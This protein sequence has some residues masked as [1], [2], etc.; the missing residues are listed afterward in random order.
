[1]GYLEKMNDAIQYVEE[2]LTGDIDYDIISKIA[3][4]EKSSFQRMFLVMTD[5]TISEYIRKR[6]LQCAIM[7]LVETTDQVITIAMKYG[8]DSAAS[9][10][11][12]IRSFTN[13]TPSEIRK[14]KTQVHFPRIQF[15][16]VMKEGKMSMNDKTIVRIEEHYGEKVIRFDVDCMEPETEA[17]KLMSEWCRENVTDRVGRR[18]LGLAPKGHHPDGKEHENAEEHVSHPYS[19]MMVLLGE[20]G[21]QDT[22]CGKKVEDAP[23]GLFLVNEVLLNQYDEY[24]NLDMA[25]SMMKASEAFMEF[26]KNMKG[27]DFDYEQGI[28]YEEHI[29]SERWFQEGGFPDGFRMWVPIK[30]IQ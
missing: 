14:R 28:F 16:M 23:N 7:D 9:F 20:E 10:T 13:Q 3:C 11:R 4:L 21:Q 5:M 15:E 1:M 24:G 18:Y 17:W 22:Y 8:Y 25:R 2:H 29:F 30:K 19:A 27:Y 6:R 12:A 26:M